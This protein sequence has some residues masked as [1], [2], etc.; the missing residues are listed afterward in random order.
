MMDTILRFLFGG[1]IVTIFAVIGDVFRPRS[2][3]GLFGAAP[4][5]ALA[6]LGLTFAKEGAGYVSTEGRS[7]I[8]GAAGLFAYSLVTSQL[9]KKRNWHG[10]IAAGLSY[11]VWFG[12]AFLLWALFLR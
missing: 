8:A 7:M 11:I 6:T 9:L 5:V 2:F 3:S 4:T 1:M 10:L 12:A